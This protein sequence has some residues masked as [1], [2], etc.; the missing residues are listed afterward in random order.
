MRGGEGQV[1]GG[2][3]Q[4]RLGEWPGLGGGIT[5]SCIIQ[6]MGAGR[7]RAVRPRMV[8]GGEGKWRYG[9]GSERGGDITTPGIQVRE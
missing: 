7:G 6:A 9:A 4:H 8:Q 1:Q 5:T 2:V 3:S